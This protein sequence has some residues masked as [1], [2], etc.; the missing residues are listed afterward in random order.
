MS[1]DKRYATYSTIS[2][3][4]SGEEWQW[5]DEAAQVNVS[6]AETKLVERKFCRRGEA[7][8]S[9]LQEHCNL[10]SS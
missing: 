1:L 7:L 4:N 5:E 8:E 6:E 2:K 3:K 9:G 10:G